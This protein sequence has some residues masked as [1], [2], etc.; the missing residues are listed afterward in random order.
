MSW[1]AGTARSPG[2]AAVGLASRSVRLG[3]DNFVMPGGMESMSNA[4]YMVRRLRSGL[5]M[6]DA[7]M[8]DVMVHDGLFCA[9]DQCTMPKATPW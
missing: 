9:F 5:G 2:Q 7:S 4:P 3:E 8:V 1:W 6:G